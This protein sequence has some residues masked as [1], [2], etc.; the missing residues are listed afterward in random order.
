MTLSGVHLS[1]P[2]PK[3]VPKRSYC[4]HFRF[5][6][7]WNHPFLAEFKRWLHIFLHSLESKEPISTIFRW[8]QRLY[9]NSIKSNDAFLKHPFVHMAWA[10]A[11]QTL[12]A[13]WA[14]GITS[15]EQRALVSCRLLQYLWRN[16][17]TQVQLLRQGI[18]LTI[19][20]S[21]TPHRT[22][23][24]CEGGKVFSFYSITK[25]SLGSRGALTPAKKDEQG[26]LGPKE[27]EWV[28][29]WLVTEN[30]HTSS[31]LIQNCKLWLKFSLLLVSTEKYEPPNAW[32]K[33]ASVRNT[34][35]AL[36]TSKT[37]FSAATTIPSGRTF[38][39]ETCSSSML[40]KSA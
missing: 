14:A 38:S 39:W 17:V 8:V 24:V 7:W 18:T 34:T 2:E 30:W 35:S 10:I 40:G 12:T 36:T 37:M 21:S 9:E 6:K 11:Q 27:C 13:H 25:L 22:S 32:W 16:S 1:I 28:L 15:V 33:Q 26:C 19:L 3:G 20:I 31:L 4:N 5:S 29:S 23:A